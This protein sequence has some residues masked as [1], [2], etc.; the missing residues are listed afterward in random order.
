MRRLVAVIVCGALLTTGCASAGGSR[1]AAAPQPGVDNTA[2]AEY[3][4]RLPVGSKIRVDR[5][6]GATFK[7]T[8][9][10]TSPASLIV[11]KSTRIAEPPV[12][13]PFGQLARVTVDTGNGSSTAKAVGIG[14]ATGLG[15]FFTI[16]AIIAASVD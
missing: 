9:I 14:I 16:L 13:V 7:G 15:A 1:V 2:L 6:D 11:Q 8:L 5:T 10:K 4:Q 3:V 12:E